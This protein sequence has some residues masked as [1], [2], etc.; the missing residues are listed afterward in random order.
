MQ[1]NVRQ[2][3]TCP[4]CQ[5][6]SALVAG[7]C[8]RC[9]RFGPKF[10]VYASRIRSD[11]GFKKKCYELLKTDIARTGFIEMFGPMDAIGSTIVSGGCK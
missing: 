5:V 4:G 3:G 10:G 7:C 8:K 6:H 11:E 1:G 2:I 9:S